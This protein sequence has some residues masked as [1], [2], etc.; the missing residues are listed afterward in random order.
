MGKLSNL[1][2]FTKVVE[3]GS[4]AEAARQMGLS[5]AQV[6]KSVINLEDELGVR[7]LHRT[8]RSVSPTQNGEDYYKDARH[9]LST[10]A[11]ADRL[12]SE[13]DAEPRGTLRLNAPLS[14]GIQYLGSALSGFMKQYP[15]LRLQLN[16]TDRMVDPVSEGYD[17]IIRIGELEDN[18]SHLVHPIVKV[19]RFLIASPKFIQQ[20][21]PI[22]HPNDLKQL[23]CLHYGSIDKGHLWKL[24]GANQTLKVKVNGVMC[25]N[26][27]DVLKDAAIAGLGIAMLPTFITGDALKSGQLAQ[28]LPKYWAGD[29]HL[30]VICPS[31]RYVSYKVRTLIE[32]LKD[33]FGKEPDWGTI[34]RPTS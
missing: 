25:A 27:G 10:L 19:R 17:A 32:F 9:I 14:F 15:D 5:R 28:I 12:V 26:N 3:H 30:M 21:G 33:R 29:L 1:R 11:E 31:D 22:D 23:P 34:G 7:L 24:T 13:R 18:S 6:S 20:R 8:T 2:A 16:L 4:F